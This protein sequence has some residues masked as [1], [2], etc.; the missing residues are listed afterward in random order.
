MST[1]RVTV[2]TI[3]GGKDEFDMELK[4]MADVTQRGFILFLDNEQTLHV[5]AQERI[6]YITVT[7]YHPTKSDV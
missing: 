1:N 3:Y 4:S 6:E 2:H 5:F 7:N